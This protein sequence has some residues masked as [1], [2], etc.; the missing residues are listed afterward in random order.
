M[1]V[2]DLYLWIVF[3][4]TGASILIEESVLDETYS[5]FGLLVTAPFLF[6]I[7]LFFCLQMFGSL[8]MM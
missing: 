3:V 5:R 2:A 4:G 7:S 1:A 8:T 6:C